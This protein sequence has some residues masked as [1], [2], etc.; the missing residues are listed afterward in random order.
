M[1]IL[2]EGLA[3]GAFGMIRRGSPGRTTLLAQIQPQDACLAGSV[4]PRAVASGGLSR[5]RG[6]PMSRTATRRH[7]GPCV[8]MDSLWRRICRKARWFHFD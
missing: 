5:L 1:Q 6:P 3:L 4:I 7:R 8:I 2:I